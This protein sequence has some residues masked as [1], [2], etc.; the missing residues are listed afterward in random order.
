MKI[1]VLLFAALADRA[2]TRILDLSVPPGTTVD[3]AVQQLLAGSPQLAH[4][5]SHLLC[6]VNQ[7][8]VDKKHQLENGDELALFPPV[9]GG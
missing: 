5:Q 1:T 2:G 6:A 9:S 3:T 4:F 7:E 8:Y